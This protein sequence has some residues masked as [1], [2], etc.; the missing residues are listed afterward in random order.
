MFRIAGSRQEHFQNGDK[1]TEFNGVILRYR[2]QSCRCFSF[3]TGVPK[4][5]VYLLYLHSRQRRIWNEYKRAKT[6]VTETLQGPEVS[7]SHCTMIFFLTLVKVMSSTFIMFINLAYWNQNRAR[8]KQIDS[9][10]E[11]IILNGSHFVEACN[12]CLC[13]SSEF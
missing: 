7:V 3:L 13:L 9:E 12:C 11:A 10:N 4:R 6:W 1:K 8:R 2:G 5:R